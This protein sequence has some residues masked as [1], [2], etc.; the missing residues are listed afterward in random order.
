[1]SAGQLEVLVDSLLKQVRDGGSL[2]CSGGG[3]DTAYYIFHVMYY[4]VMDQGKNPEIELSGLHPAMVRLV[5]QKY[6]FHDKPSQEVNG[7]SGRFPFEAIPVLQA[8]CARTDWPTNFPRIAEDKRQNNTVR[9]LIILSLYQA[10][11]AQLLVND[12]LAILDGETSLETRL[13]ALIALATA[14]KG[15]A[16]LATPP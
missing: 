11:E 9:L 5:L 3:P 13:I 10:G 4:G 12:L 8:L 7:H 15:A 14:A 16:G 6:G 1:M 2:S